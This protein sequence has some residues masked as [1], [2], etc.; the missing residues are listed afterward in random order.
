V[1]LTSIV[2]RVPSVKIPP[3]WVLR[4]RLRCKLGSVFVVAYIRPPVIT[5]QSNAPARTLPI[6]LRP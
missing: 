6:H 1:R 5:L 3:A 4:T 2:V